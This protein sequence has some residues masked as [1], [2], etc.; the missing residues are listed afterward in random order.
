MMGFDMFFFNDM[1][2]VFLFGFF[3]SGM[4]YFGL[5]LSGMYGLLLGRLNK[6][7]LN[8]GKKNVWLKGNVRKGGNRV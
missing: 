2:F 8:M 4:V 6:F 5:F 3:G 7:F 1:F